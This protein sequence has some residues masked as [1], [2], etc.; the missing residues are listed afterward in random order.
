M[1]IWLNYFLSNM[2]Q[3]SIR[4]ILFFSSIIKICIEV[5]HLTPLKIDIVNVSVHLFT[6]VHKVLTTHGIVKHYH[7]SGFLPALVC[8]VC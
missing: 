8:K 5:K 2:I 3:L 7:T 1:L 6:H 4:L